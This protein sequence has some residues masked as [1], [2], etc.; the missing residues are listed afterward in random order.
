MALLIDIYNMKIQPPLQREHDFWLFGF[1]NIGVVLGGFGVDFGA[2]LASKLAQ[3]ILKTRNMR[4]R[5][6]SRGPLKFRAFLLLIFEVYGMPFGCQL[7][8]NLAPKT[9]PRRARDPNKSEKKRVKNRGL[10]WE[11]PRARK[12]DPKWHSRPEFCKVFGAILAGFSRIFQRIFQVMRAQRA[13]RAERRHARHRRD[14]SSLLISFW[15]P[16]DLK[17][18]PSSAQVGFKMV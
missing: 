17:L 7:W 11:P 18:V 2:V 3:K 16:W 14:L 13:K 15:G 1:S 5:G 12:W 4:I 10:C 9:A 8:S 6:G